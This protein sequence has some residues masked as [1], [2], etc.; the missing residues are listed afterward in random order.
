MRVDAD[1]FA[2][3]NLA[4]AKSPRFVV[5]IEFPT[6][7]LYLSSHD[8]IGG[9]P[10]GDSRD[11]FLRDETGAI[12]TTEAGTPILVESE[13]GTAGGALLLRG[14]LVEPTVT[15]QKLN[16]DQ[17]R[18]E[19]GAA[20]FV[21]LD[22]SGALT[23]ALQESL[24]FGDG[25]RNKTCRFYLGYEGLDWS[26]FQLVA[27][28]IIKSATYDRGAYRVSCNDI[29]RSARK[30]IFELATTTL[31]S[32]VESADTTIN[33]TSTTGFELLK[34]GTAYSDAASS[35]VGYVKIK[36][37][38]I[39]YTGTTATSFTGCTRGVLGTL[40]GRYVVDGGTPSARREKVTEYVYLEMPGPKL[41]Y[42]ILTG[43]LYDS[44][45]VLPTKWHLGISD[46]L[47]DGAEF[48]AIGLD[49]WDPDDDTA[50]TVLRFEG[51]TKQDGKAFL[52]LEIMRLM[53]LYMPVYADGTLGL[54]RMTRVLA[55]ASG[56]ATL[57]ESNSVSV[58]D[59]DH[60]MDGMYNAFSVQWNWNGK[61]Y[62][63][64]TTFLD[65]TSAGVHGQA[66]T[67]DLK[68]KGLYGGRHTDGAIFKLLDSIRDRYS[69][70][71][72]RMKAEVFNRLNVIEVGDV[73]RCKH[74]TVR[75]FT[76]PGAAIDRSFEVQ[77]VSI[78]HRT[79]AVSL[80][81]F[82]STSTASVE[83]PTTPT[84][85]LPDAFYTAAGTDLASIWT[86]TSGVVS[87]GPYTLAGAATLTDT[88]SIFYYNGDLTIPESVTVNLT[89]N[90]QIRVKGYLTINGTLNGTGGGLAGVADN[91]TTTVI[92][93]NPGWV[94]NSRGHDG[95]VRIEIR[96]SGVRLR[97]NPPLL[98]QAKHSAFPVMQLEVVGNDLLGL[99]A[100][101]RG[102]GGGPGGKIVQRNGTFN[103]SGG[104]GGDGGAGL[105]TISRGLGLGASAVIR[106]DGEST[107]AAPAYTVMVSGFGIVTF[108][109]GAGGGGG[110]GSYLLLIDGGLL[111]VP[112]LSG[113]FQARCGSVGVPAYE[114]ALTSRD[115]EKFKRDL[116]PFAGYLEEPSVISGLDLSGSCSRIQY[117]PAPET[118]VE[119]TAAPPPV[120]GVSITPAATG[121]TVSFTPGTGTR[122]GTVFEVWQY[123]AS[124]PFSSATKV[125][126]GATTSI[127]VG[128][129]ATATVYVWVR[130][131]F[132]D[133][134]GITR[135]SSTTPA[136]AGVPAAIISAGTYAIASPSSVSASAGSTSVTT[137]TVTAS[138]VGGTATTYAWTRVSGSTSI[139]ANSASAAATTFTATP[140]AAGQT[141]S[142]IFRCTITDNL[143]PASTYTVDVPV[144]CTNA[145]GVL[146]VTASPTSVSKTEDAATITTATV[147]AAA[148]GGAGPY[149]YAWTKLSGGSI[150]A[151]SASS[152]ATT[153]T[154]A[155]MAAAESRSAIFRCTAT[156]SASPVATAT[157]DVQVTVTRAGFSVSIAPSSLFVTGYT[158]EIFTP[159]VT[160]TPSGGTG[161]Y[162]YAWTRVSGSTLSVSAPLSAST[163]FS[164]YS[165]AA[166]W[167]ANSVYRVTVTDSTGATATRDITIDIERY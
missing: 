145:V 122:D 115:E 77:G 163:T 87:G 73:V 100:D 20:S 141:L 149:T 67:M 30:D 140:V 44:A 59:L 46:A 14:C 8:D 29:Q 5:R 49:M 105:C 111:S 62:T 39:R 36:D 24:T 52:E 21:A 42:A 128:R 153:F 4:P 103:A 78:N 90:V 9:I 27:T 61:E 34:H 107:A 25:M 79:G 17:G 159:G 88:A 3:L 106:L 155:T 63:R 19:I 167:V 47:V 32:T 151:V 57:D 108:Y 109:P 125:A 38:V 43:K 143:S 69:A 31:A 152:A 92:G 165:A 75:D 64:T 82:G 162:A 84:T 99:P 127:F 89:G 80:D 160:A 101:L 112:D 157:V 16:P 37:E 50:G 123:T 10:A 55:D 118:P 85:A 154:A 134:D 1:S 15:S 129:T 136:G 11:P 7:Y 150:T 104:S 158:A 6:S 58:G 74:R 81:L 119:D 91:A 28:Q 51:L 132:R 56:V 110:P 22:R 53:G 142:A 130:A 2:A 114:T 40:A 135:Y 121:Y 13:L 33:V 12:L 116:E 94:G 138:L 161:P 133:T 54:R 97:T 71:P 139:S 83:S 156:D 124:T 146:A 113:R 95:L 137:A 26:E 98:T 72:I 144:E 45:D 76:Q 60:D 48:A 35:T 120:S 147:T 70:P 86:I 148:T 117:V 166:E 96:E 18:A 23:A 66:P 68:F 126:E 131:R 93:G 41:A 164:Y 102:T 65:A